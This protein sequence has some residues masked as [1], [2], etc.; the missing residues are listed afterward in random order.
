MASLSGRGQ[1]SHP[2]GWKS[3][4]QAFDTGAPS[5]P[6]NTLKAELLLGCWSSLTG[7]RRDEPE[8][9]PWEHSE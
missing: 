3:K 6:P 9:A 8:S 5:L 7:C 2:L 1:G 4:P